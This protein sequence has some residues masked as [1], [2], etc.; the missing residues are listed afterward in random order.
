MIDMIFLLIVF[1]VLV[2]RIVDRERVEMNLPQPRKAAAQKV[3]EESRIVVNV[4]PG[5]NGSIEGYRVGGNAFAPTAA[6][7]TAMTAHLMK[8]H[9]LNP[10]IHINIRADRSTQ[11]VHV[12]PVMAAVSSAAR[13]A[14]NQG[15]GRVNLIVVQ[16]R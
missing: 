6:G 5:P 1:F 14:G 7:I 13:A 16:E 2:S 3:G 12:E 10:A 15:G 8:L 9:Q 11:Y 4:M